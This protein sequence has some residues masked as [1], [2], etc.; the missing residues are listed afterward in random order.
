MKR[1]TFV[2][3]LVVSDIIAIIPVN[4]R[5]KLNCLDCLTHDQIAEIIPK[6]VLADASQCRHFKQVTPI[7]KHKF[8]N[9][10]GGNFH[11]EATKYGVK[12]Q[13]I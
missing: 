10:S 9:N 4:K 1:L 12:V 13:K 3:D 2:K 8:F 5:P 7:T 11:A 6:A